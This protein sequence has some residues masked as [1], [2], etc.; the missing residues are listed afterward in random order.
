MRPVQIARG[1]DALRSL[2]NARLLVGLRPDK[3]LRMGAAIARTGFGN[4]VGIAV[5]AQ[6][7]PERPAVIDELGVLSYRELDN[8]ANALGAALQQ[9]PGGADNIWLAGYSG[10]SQFITQFYLPLHGDRL[11]GGGAVLFAGG[12]EPY[13]V[14]PRPVS[15]R[16]R[17]A[18]PMF[19]YTGAGDVPRVEIIALFA[20]IKRMPVGAIA[21]RR[22]TDTH[23]RHIEILPVG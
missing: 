13:S 1:R 20:T 15:A 5:S 22:G 23:Q 3:Y 11:P 9:Y 21:N 6:R 16:Q 14:T 12:G 7:C 8:R 19:W 10:G 18:F 17:A 2:V 4:T